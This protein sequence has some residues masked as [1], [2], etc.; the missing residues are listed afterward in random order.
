MP[1]RALPILKRLHRSIQHAG[2][3]PPHYLQNREQLEQM[4]DMHRQLREAIERE[5]YEL[6]ARLRDSIRQ[7]EAAG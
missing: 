1:I 4:V 6:A 5:D 7:K 2:K 3:R